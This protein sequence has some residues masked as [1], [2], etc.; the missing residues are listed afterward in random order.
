MA[1]QIVISSLDYE[2]LKHNAR[3][4][5]CMC[6]R[7][8]VCVSRLESRHVE[9]KLCAYRVGLSVW[10]KINPEGKFKHYFFLYLSCLLADFLNIY[11]L[12]CLTILSLFCSLN[13]LFT[14]L[15]THSFT[16][17]LLTHSSVIHSIHTYC[18]HFSHRWL[19][20]TLIY[21]IALL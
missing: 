18:H 2:N 8:S 17:S 19:I 3:Y 13:Y 16:C 20:C 9:T 12:T 21:S 10:I 6:V 15:Y 1:N 7:V 14:Q 5:C 4:L 11:L